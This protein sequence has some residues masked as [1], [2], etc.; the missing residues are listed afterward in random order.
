MLK[1]SEGDGCVG[2]IRGEKSTRY[3]TG[4]IIVKQLA[5]KQLG[6]DNP[7]QGRVKRGIGVTHFALKRNG[8]QRGR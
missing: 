2:R 3:C 6:L 4:V 8:V 5:A 7:V 1:E